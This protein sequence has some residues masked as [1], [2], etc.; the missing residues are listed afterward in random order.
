M[1]EADRRSPACPGRSSLQDAVDSL[2]D[3]YELAIVENKNNASLEMYYAHYRAGKNEYMESG[4]AH[5]YRLAA[6]DIA[7]AMQSVI[8]S[9]TFIPR[10]NLDEEI[11]RKRFGEASEIIKN[12][13]GVKYYLFAGKGLAIALSNEKKDVLQYVAP[14]EFSRLRDPLLDSTPSR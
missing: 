10:V 12:Q 4:T 2:G 14:G 5:K 8:D 3:D 1:R 9:I 13:P 6:G 11:I 7:Q